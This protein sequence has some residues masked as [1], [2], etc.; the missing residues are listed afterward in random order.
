MRF[1][2]LLNKLGV[3]RI[4]ILLITAVLVAL[5]SI[6]FVVYLLFNVESPQQTFDR[7]SQSL[8]THN[9]HE[10]QRHIAETE[11][12][13]WRRY[14]TTLARDESAE[15]ALLYLFW[16]KSN[17]E[18]VSRSA[19]S[20]DQETL[21]FMITAPDAREILSS[22]RKDAE[23]GEIDMSDPDI[24]RVGRDPVS[25]LLYY[26]QDYYS[27]YESRTL[28]DE[29][30]L[31]FRLEGNFFNRAWKLEPSAEL[32]SLLSGHLAKAVRDVFRQ[33]LALPRS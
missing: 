3:T 21:R 31:E 29:I 14:F 25:T 24:V 13:E 2:N 27:E 11:K 1:N 6:S 20:E 9:F 18:L 32:H 28:E 16:E 22:V 15:T 5:G 26:V 4:I 23:S 7:Y 12:E 30:V 10:A 33:P 8:K 19:L 17:W